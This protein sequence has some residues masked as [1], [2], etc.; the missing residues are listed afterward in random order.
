MEHQD[1]YQDFL[2]TFFKITSIG[3]SETVGVN[4]LALNENDLLARAE[5][6]SQLKAINAI[7]K[8]DDG[9]NIYGIIG[10]GHE[11][12]I[13]IGSHMDSV[14][15][16]GRYDG[17]YGVIG[18]LQIL[19]KYARSNINKRLILIDFTNEEGAR[20][21]PS[22]LGSGLATEALT[23][24]FVYSRKDSQGISFE[25]AL[26]KSGYMGS[27][28]NRIKYQNPNYYLELH[29]E[30]GPVLEREGF[31]IGIPKGIVHLIEERYTFVGEANQAGPT[32][33]KYRK[34]ALVAASRFIFGVREMA[35]NS[36]SDL[37]MTVGQIQNIPNVYNVIPGK[38]SLTL[39]IRSPEKEVAE[40]YSSRTKELAEK[41]ASEEGVSLTKER[42]WVFER[43][44]F[45][46]DLIKE[47]EKACQSL[48]FKYKIMESWAGH[49]AY[50]MSK[51][52]RTAMIF[53]PS[54]N[55]RS[56]CKEEYSSD[57]DLIRGFKVLEKTVESLMR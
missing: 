27:K 21:Q 34:D 45:D 53:I 31:Q 28:D 23:K 30:Q 33:M 13:S 12:T 37:V 1:F 47:I 4:R 39:D 9:G 50:H 35:K 42:L 6:E 51:I 36:A 56:H 43:T 19:K 49:D 16:G 32:P 3:W 22:L 24:D 5:L 17:M 48:G 44:I 57:E 14:P 26:K 29:I 15:N 54:H 20:W 10:E 41:I 55:G 7:I 46:E 40:E 52:T 25:E 8:H 2:K 18:G 11:E 38:V